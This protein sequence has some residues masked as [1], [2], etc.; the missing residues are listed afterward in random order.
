M[1]RLVLVRHAAVEID[2]DRPAPLWHLSA[3]GRAATDALADEG[4]LTEAWNAIDRLYVSSEPKAIATAQRIAARHELPIT[5]VHDLREVEGRA[6]VEQGYDEQ[7][8]RYFA[9]EPVAGWEARDAAQARVTSAIEK[10]ET[11]DTAIVSHGLAL[12]LYLA[13]LLDLDAEAAYE[14]WSSIAFPDVAIVDPAAR[15]LVRPFAGR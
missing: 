9:G 6:W 15:T 1:T 13:G 8:R 4:T 11:G 10:I 2:R 14:M 3:E 5:I 12:T 7:V